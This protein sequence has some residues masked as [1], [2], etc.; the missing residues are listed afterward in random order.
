[1]IRKTR[2]YTGWILFIYI[3]THL[4]N[5]M[6]GLWS[7]EAMDQ[8]RL[9]LQSPWNSDVGQL[10]LTITFI[11]HGS[12]AF[13]ALYNRRRFA[14]MDTGEWFQ[15]VFG[16][17]IPPM[18]II[19][20]IGTLV[21]EQVY[22]TDP[23]YAWLLL[24][25]WKGDIPTGIRQ[26]VVLL[27]AW[28]HGCLGIYFW[29]RLKQGWQKWRMVALSTA[30]IYPILAL[31]GIWSAS[32]E[33]LVLFNDSAWLKQVISQTNQPNN[34]QLATLNQWEMGFLIG[35]GILLLLVLGARQVRPFWEARNGIVK[36]YYDTGKIVK[37]IPGISFLDISREFAQP[38]ASVCGGRGRCST[39]RIRINEGIEKLPAPGPEERKILERIKAAPDIRLACQCLPPKGNYNISCIMPADTNA[40]SLH[41]E[42][43]FHQGQEKEITVLFADLR[44]FT[45]LSE[46]KLPYDV[47]FI[48][49]RFFAMMGIAVDQNDG[50]L[51][52]FIGDGV[53]ALFGI[54]DD[55][56]KGAK[57]A[58]QTANDMVEGIARLNESLSGDLK[59]HLEIGIG[60]HTG[61][62]IIGDMGYGNATQLT[63]IGD[64]V[65]TASRLESLTKDLDC[66]L[67]ISEDT[68]KA[69]GI[70]G[71]DSPLQET[72]IRGREQRLCIN[73]LRRHQDFSKLLRALETSAESKE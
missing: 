45:R 46:E 53:M 22:D 40:K 2:L 55:P 6:I 21:I 47:V 11:I 71:L 28:T 73:I 66:D 36:I 32:K 72:A 26:M 50:H 33:V 4:A 27:L 56:H 41:L 24:I 5:H 7:L 54:D 38:H 13:Y 19:H 58:I 17:S 15:L 37:S 25:Y 70:S 39:C 14:S 35:Y 43:D 62:A 1:M 34:E 23:N 9:W 61:P 29:L 42:N 16:L 8:A 65:N 31:L 10:L 30:L 48:L 20:Y 67:I 49:N 68:L 69:A 63:A 52:K 64:T 51:D 60:L 57:N 44:G 18:L 3:L 59:Y 12:L